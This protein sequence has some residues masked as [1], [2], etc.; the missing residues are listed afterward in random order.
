MGLNQFLNN[1]SGLAS[2]LPAGILPLP[3]PY[4]AIYS[5]KDVN[6]DWA[7]GGLPFL[8][9]ETLRGT[10]FRR[11]Y[12]REYAPI[13]KDQFDAQN[14]PGEQS[15]LGF[16]LRSQN[17]FT[18]GAGIQ[19]LDPT[20]DQAQELRYSY[21][22]GLDVMSQ[23]GQVT[24]LQATKT[25]RTGLTGPI[26][27]RG[28]NKSGTDGVLVVD[29]GLRTMTFLDSAGT[30]TPYTLPG[31][32]TGF[33]NTF[34]DDGTNYYIA[35]K[36][37][38]YQGVIATPA[39]PAVKIW[40]VP[41]T[42]G[43]YVIAWVK[44]RLVG[45]LD[46]GVYE[47]VGA[48][49]PTLPTVKFTH[50]NPAYTFS[51]ISEIPAAIIVSGSAG[52][53]QSQVH[54][55]T[56]DTGGAL[57]VMT[58]GVVTATMPIGETIKAMY[59]YIGT[60]VGLGTNKGFRVATVDTQGNLIYGPL[61]VQDPTSV[62]VQAIG[63]YDRFL[64]IGNQGN[65]LVP[66]VGWQNPS[67]AS[68]ND[69]LMRVDLSNTTQSGQNPVATDLMTTGADGVINAVVN[70]GTSTAS[71]G[72]LCFSTGT[73]VWLTDTA[74]K[75]TTGFLYTGKIRYNTLEPKH[76]KYVSLR[77]Q[78]ITDG[79]MDIA[80]QNKNMLLTTLIP[81]VT[82]LPDP[83]A[84]I[85]IPDMGNAQEWLQLKFVL[86]RGTVNANVSPVWNGYQLRSL[87]GVNRQ[88]LLTLPLIVT[89][90]ERDNLGNIVG[91]NGFTKDRVLAL[92]AIVQS[93]NVVTVQDLQN[94]ITYLAF[95]EEYHYEQQANP[96]KGEPMGG[97]VLLQMRVIQ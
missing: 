35:D 67:E 79:S 70:F 15:F 49:G 2:P 47:L 24:L 26:Q 82:G 96:Q 44:G 7:I 50:L 56:L 3:G 22:E 74:N 42:S 78:N 65:K 89:D 80:A 33:A 76:F 10:Y 62:G 61:D 20:I 72:M 88:L 83:N 30:S 52:A 9:G 16:W 87:P 73:K 36:T 27:L 12:L 31:G 69:M 40:N 60:F 81:N 86:H 53:V 68:T 17:T 57:P 64:F 13:R 18:Q 23:A 55:F 1:S 39:T 63:G 41:S 92:E 95:M 97:Y 19:Y 14:I 45:A 28:V 71:A 5:L 85:F 48:G 66:L 25:I 54:K 90:H 11:Q 29:I 21:S 8:A 84:P 93:G 75:Q 58:S 32:L 77:S 59:S 51:A 34:T 4:S 38:I 91:Y 43:N 37:G 46:N 94:G 6:F